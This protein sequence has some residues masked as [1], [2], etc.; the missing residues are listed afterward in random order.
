MYLSSMLDVNLIYTIYW[1][2]SLSVYH[3][4]RVREYVSHKHLIPYYN[5]HAFVLNIYYFIV[6]KLVH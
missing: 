4:Q 1:S 5:M 3:T 6:P 2:M